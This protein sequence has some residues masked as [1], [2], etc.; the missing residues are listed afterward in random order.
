MASSP[1]SLP[2]RPPFSPKGVAEQ[3]E[4]RQQEQT[5]PENIPYH[6]SIVRPF[7]ARAE[8]T[9]IDVQAPRQ[10]EYHGSK[11]NCLLCFQGN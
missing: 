8:T 11:K 7:R 9:A 6:G 1:L 4:C 2:Y 3:V 5:V 10:V